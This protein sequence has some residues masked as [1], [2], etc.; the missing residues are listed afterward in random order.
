VGPLPTFRGSSAP[1][2]P[3]VSTLE[4]TTLLARKVKIKRLCRK[5]NPLLVTIPA[6]S[7]GS[8]YILGFR[9]NIDVIDIK[10]CDIDIDNDILYL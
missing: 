8:M 3:L 5:G 6:R 10:Y 1:P 2:V 4:V 9:Y 7:G